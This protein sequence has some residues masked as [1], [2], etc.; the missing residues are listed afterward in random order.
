MKC[1]TCKKTIVF[2]SCNGH[3]NGGTEFVGGGEYGSRITDDKYRYAIYVCDDCMEF[4]MKDKCLVSIYTESVTT[5]YK[6]IPKIEDDEDD[7]E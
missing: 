3:P 6:R 5:K 4:R 1:L 7:N 2:Q